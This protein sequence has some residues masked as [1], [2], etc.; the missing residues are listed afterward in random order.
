MAAVLLIIGL[1][2]FLLGTLGLLVR[3]RERGKPALA[4]L[5]PMVSAP[6]AR[7]CWPD[8]WFFVLARLLGLALVAAGFGVAVARDPLILEE[9][10]RLWGVEPRPYVAGSER[11]EMNRF[12]NASE[13]ILM[14]IRRD[15]NKDL[16]GRVHGQPF[17]Y[18]RV[19]L[20]DGVLSAR[21]GSG[22]LPEL[23]VRIFLESRL[24]EASFDERK[25]VSVQPG[26]TVSPA[27]HLSWLDEQGKLQTRIIQRGYRM[28]LQ[29]ARVDRHQ[30]KGFL[31][32]ILPDSTRS[33]LSGKF[34]AYTNHLRYE[35]GVVDRGY[36]HPDTLEY[37]AR[38]YLVNQF[39]GG[40]IER[41][42]FS[43]TRIQ[44]SRTEGSTVARIQLDG[45]RIER[46]QIGLQL[47]R[48]EWVVRRETVTTEVL[49]ERTADG[50]DKGKEDGGGRDGAGD[51]SAQSGASKG[52]V[53]VAFADLARHTGKRI[54]TER[55]D[56]KVQQGRLQE[57]TD[58]RIVLET[59]LSGGT[60][61]YYVDRGKLAR[62][63]LPDGRTLLVG[64]HAQGESS[65]AD[66]AAGEQ[67]EQGPEQSREPAGGGPQSDKTGDAELQR[68]RSLE[69]KRVTITAMDGESRTGI[70]KA[71][72]ERE[73]TLTVPMGGGSVDYYYK[74]DEIRS[75]ERADEA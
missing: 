29:L 74:P 27:I 13:A 22:F 58:R 34:I 36:T 30:L 48:G 57:V 1:T 2:L 33:F 8:V 70:L 40:A 24:K 6:F 3:F 4:V 17:T 31:Q 15:T 5:V 71:V 28:E 52:P 64:E 59:N 72:G 32:L 14:A 67:Q 66:G 39:P 68:L 69:G 19:E 20:I 41:I 43:D 49:Q 62:V 51:S 65:V 7:E 12:V 61:E 53:R 35:Q 23:E 56:G 16:S 46:R 26:D 11:V 21:Q 55:T 10:R 37:V 25:T 60:V 38:H 18:D 75:F 45:G 54:R 47:A 42:S 50:G 63:G 44:G 9:P 73:I